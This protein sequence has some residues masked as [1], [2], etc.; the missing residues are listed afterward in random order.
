MQHVQMRTVCQHIT[1]HSLITFHHANMH[2]S[3]LRI[4]VRQNVLSSTRHVSFLAAPDTDHQHMF[5]LT[6]LSNLTFCTPK[7]VVS[8]S[9]IYTA[10]IHGGVAVPRI[11]NL[12]Q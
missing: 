8:R 7:L 9:I 3:S 10:T 12:T 6:Y 11:S 1:L 4:C 5:S 2:G